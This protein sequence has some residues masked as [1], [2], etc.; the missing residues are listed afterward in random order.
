MTQ[1]TIDLTNH[2]GFQLSLLK[3]ATIPGTNGPTPS[4]QLT[5]EARLIEALVDRLTPARNT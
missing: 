1:A 2:L 5:Q 4:N 3:L